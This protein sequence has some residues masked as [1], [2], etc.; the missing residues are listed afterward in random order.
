MET[1]DF[2][3]A[4]SDI[5]DQEY[6]DPDIIQQEEHNTEMEDLAGYLDTIVD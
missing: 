5:D 2:V 4:R 3:D 1:E 6:A